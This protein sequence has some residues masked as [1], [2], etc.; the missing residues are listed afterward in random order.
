MEERY[1][2]LAARLGSLKEKRAPFEAVWDKAAELCALNS[3]IYTVSNDGRIIR[4][5]FDSTGRTALT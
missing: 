5:I 1:K 4:N 3:A 2:Y